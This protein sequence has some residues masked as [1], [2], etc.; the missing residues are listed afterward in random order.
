MILRYLVFKEQFLP[1]MDLYATYMNELEKKLI[2]LYIVKAKKLNAATPLHS[3]V[4]YIN[5]IKF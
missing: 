2:N 1:K 4:S 5:S 3:G